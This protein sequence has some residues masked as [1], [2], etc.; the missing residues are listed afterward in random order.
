MERIG[1]APALVGYCLGGTMAVAAATNAKTSGVATIAAPWHFSAFPDE[2]RDKLQALW[3]GSAPTVA[4]MGLLP[5]EVLQSGFWSLDP[6]RTVAKFERFADLPADSPEADG[7]VLLED[8]ANDGPPIPG[9]AAREMFED[10]FRDDV[11]GAG[12]W[13]VCGRRVDPD[14][15]P[16][17]LFNIVSTTDRIVP[18]DSAIRAGQRLDLGSGHVGMVV[19]SRA[20]ETLWQPLAAW[21]SHA[22]SS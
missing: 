19:G 18:W 14:E 6:F 22:T 13:E 7:F 2:A 20:R 9:A 12:D 1:T 3:R 10:F 11:T 5:M 8:W 21:L 4:A 16:C 15:L 17:P